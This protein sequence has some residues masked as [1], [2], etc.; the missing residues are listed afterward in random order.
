MRCLYDGLHPC[1]K[2]PACLAN[3]QRA[4]MFRL[5]Q[6]RESCSFYYWLTL[7]YD[8]E[9]V[10]KKDGEYCF[11][12]S[13]CRKFFEKLRQLYR[14]QKIGFKHF[15]VSE[16]GPNGT[17]RPH[18]HCLLMVYAPEDI[19]IKDTYEL[20]TEM[21]DYL[22]H[23]AWPYGYVCEKSFHGRVLSYLTKY[24]C[25]PE[26]VGDFHKMKP[27]TLISQGIGLNLLS[28]LGDARIERMK[29]KLDFTLL[30]NGSKI[31]LPRYY[32]QK[33]APHSVQDLISADSID[34]Y[35]EISE[36]R[37]RLSRMQSDLSLN[38]LQK[39]Q[40]EFGSYA[41]YR[42]AL[43]SNRDYAYDEFKSKIKKRK[44]L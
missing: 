39:I 11:D 8:E 23:K 42:E 36:R 24:C 7:Q 34:E 35:L 14:K 17:H 1:G 20:R 18:Y 2:C 10:P 3:R 28:T 12:K 21:R 5:D 44:N 33:I 6:E 19:S 37:R 30:Y 22:L 16:Y 41:S 13:H 9:H 43:K 27:F 4:F 31:K 25:K 40:N 26:L 15:L 29:E 32:V 38:R